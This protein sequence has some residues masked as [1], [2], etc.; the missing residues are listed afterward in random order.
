MPAADFRHG[1]IGTALARSPLNPIPTPEDLVRLFS[2]LASVLVIAIL[3]PPRR[4]AAQQAADGGG[5]VPVS[6]DEAVRQAQANAPQ[7]TQAVGQT[8]VAS[9]A[10]KASIANFLPSLSFY[11]GAGHQQGSYYLQ[12]NLIPTTG[13]WGYNQNYGASIVL[14]NGGQNV[15]DYRAARASLDAAQENQIVQRYQIA[16]QVKKQYF[17]VLAAREA[18]AAAEDQ[19]KEANEQMAVTNA[20][21]AGGSKSRADSLASAVT[22]GKAQLALAKARGDLV[23][24]GTQLTHLVGATHEVTATP[25]DTG[26]VPTINLDSA[27]LVQLALHGP[28]VQQAEH[29]VSAN[30]S[31]W[32]ASLAAYL[33]TLSVGY[34]SGTSWQSQHFVLGGGGGGT[35]STSNNL[36]FGISY[37]IFSGFQREQRVVTASVDRDNAAASLRDARLAARENIAQYLAQFRTAGIEIQLQRLTIQSAE[38][39][40]AAKDAQYRAGAVQLVDVLTQQTALAQARQ[41]LIQARLDARTAKAQIEAVIGKDIE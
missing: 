36:G 9:A 34:S 10:Y 13:G 3:L 11:R 37:S 2:R 18:V 16:L 30:R 38:A 8:R 40:V 7:M 24:G 31:S 21:Y 4:A 19:V 41:A 27:Q 17:A 32:W 14:F 26:L 29:L 28:A 12:G 20:E 39:S 33:P 6:L 1:P 23:A 22:V 15:L 25:S 5:P 35:R